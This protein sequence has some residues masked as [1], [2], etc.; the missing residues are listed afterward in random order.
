MPDTKGARSTRRNLGIRAKILLALTVF[1]IVVTALFTAS[2][3]QIEKTRI[4]DGI[5]S[6]LRAAATALPLILPEGY[7]DR[8]IQKDAVTDEE[9]L[10][11]SKM[12]HEYCVANNLTYLYTYTEKDYSFYCTST[13][14]SPDEIADGSF[15]PYFDLYSEAP[16]SIYQAWTEREPIRETV[17]DRWGTVLTLFLPMETTAGT[18]FIAGADVDIAFVNGLLSDSLKRCLLLGLLAFIAILF[19]SHYASRHFAHAIQKL[20]TYTGEFASSNFNVVEAIPLR[21]EIQQLPVRYRD[22]IGSLASAFLKMEDCLA[23]YLKDLT[24]TTAIKERIENE[25]KL[26]GEI[27]ADMLPR[28]FDPGI[29]HGRV[30][31]HATMKPAREAGGDL[32]D[33][34][35]ID[36]DHL[37]FAVG[38]VSGKGVAAALFMTVAITILR[39]NANVNR[40]DR[41]DLILSRA[42][43]LLCRNN[44]ANNFLTLFLGIL[45]VRTGMLTFSDGGHNRPYLRSSNGEATSIEV[46]GG[47][48]LGVFEDLEYATQTLQLKPGDSLFLYTDGVNEA[49]AADQS[50]YGETRLANLLTALPPDAPTSVWVETVMKDVSA[51]AEGAEQ[52]DDITLLALR[53]VA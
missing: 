2:Q 25:I 28:A 4:L 37:C 5:E 6:K 41:P 3:H 17:T 15:T 27:Q 43:Q 50:F 30:D 14:S 35:F 53:I 12:I 16:Q 33:Y 40:L 34:F 32:F 19:I 7:L 46:E 51:F 48:A 45:N 24:E 52:S 1:N 11:I 47:T 31:L 39:A 21:R 36:E 38:D 44:E 13:N 9:Y 18:R 26:A 20:A 42:N 49:V 10:S 29:H 23:N 8:A 22:E